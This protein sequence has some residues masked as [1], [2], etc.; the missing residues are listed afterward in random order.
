V[1]SDRPAGRGR[2]R[3]SCV[4]AAVGILVI[5]REG[6]IVGSGRADRVKLFC[7]ARV[8]SKAFAVEGPSGFGGFWHDDWS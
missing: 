4:G 6:G 5:T 2:W 3:D 1:N 7:Y 8:G